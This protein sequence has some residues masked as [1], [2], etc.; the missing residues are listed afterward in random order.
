[1]GHARPSSNQRN[2]VQG[3]SSDNSRIEQMAKALQLM[4]EALRLLDEARA[5]AQPRAHLD[6]AIGRLAAGQPPRNT[7][8]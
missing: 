8:G 2:D 6:H 5:P 7:K 1:M 4:T 3:Q